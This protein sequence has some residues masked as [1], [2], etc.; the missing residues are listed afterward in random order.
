MGTYSA[1]P[2]HDALL[3]ERAAHRVEY[4][5]LYHRL[6]DWCKQAMIEEDERLFMADPEADDRWRAAFA[7]REAEHLKRCQ[8]QACLVARKSREEDVW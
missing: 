4:V 6:S 5:G 1:C 3:R 8:S 7:R 2:E